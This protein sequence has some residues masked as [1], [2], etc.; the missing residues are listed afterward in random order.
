MIKLFKK[1]LVLQNTLQC[2]KNNMNLRIQTEPVTIGADAT[3]PVYCMPDFWTR[4]TC[5][6]Y[7]VQ[8]V[9]TVSKRR[10]LLDTLYLLQP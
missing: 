9:C 10:T 2:P 5:T 8:Y 3:V 6:L 1:I 7:S 4:Y